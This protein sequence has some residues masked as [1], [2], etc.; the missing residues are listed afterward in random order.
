[1]DHTYF[2]KEAYKNKKIFKTIFI[3]Y[4]NYILIYIFIINYLI[5]KIFYYV[6]A[7]KKFFLLFINNK[8]KNY[9]YIFLY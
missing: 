1:M 5:F 3:N 8:Y 2:I 9:I 4:I 6:Q 7:K